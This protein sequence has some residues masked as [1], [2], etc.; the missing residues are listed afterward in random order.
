M[1]NEAGDKKSERTRSRFRGSK[2]P[3][4]DIDN[5]THILLLGNCMSLHL[6]IASAAIS[7]YRDIT[8]C[9]TCYGFFYYSI[10]FQTNS[11]ILADFSIISEL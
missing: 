1:S 3:E 11:C 10:V 5:L 7:I 6:R 4:R 8:K 9:F 2:S